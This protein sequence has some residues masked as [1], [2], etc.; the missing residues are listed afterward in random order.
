MAKDNDVDFRFGLH[1]PRDSADYDPWKI[2]SKRGCGQG[3]VTLNFLPLNANSS[4][5]PKGTDL[6]FECVPPGTDLT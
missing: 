1:A 4:R 3:H 2:I 6:S 5:T